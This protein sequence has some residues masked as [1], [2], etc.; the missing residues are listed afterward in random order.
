MPNRALTADERGGPHRRVPA[1]PALAWSQFFRRPVLGVA[2]VI[3]TVSA[4]GLSPAPSALADSLDDL[5]AAVAAYRAGS[6]CAPLRR[7]PIADKVAAVI[8]KSTSDWLDHNATQIPIEDPMP[9]LK[10]LGYHGGKSQLLA[11]SSDNSQGDAIKGLLLEGYAAILDCSYTDVG[12][13]IL[14][15]ERTGNVLSAAVLAGP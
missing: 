1:T 13:N 7:D 2:V 4:A 9:G 5:S 10:E 14:L 6:S 3:M 12:F 11:G 8:N 15:N